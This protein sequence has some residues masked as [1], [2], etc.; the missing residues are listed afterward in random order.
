M[1]SVVL[2]IGQACSN[3]VSPTSLLMSH[4]TWPHSTAPERQGTKLGFLPPHPVAFF[5]PRNYLPSL[6]PLWSG[7]TGEPGS[8]YSNED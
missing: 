3:T 2:A 5:L 4:L 7:H 1:M 6:G 8:A